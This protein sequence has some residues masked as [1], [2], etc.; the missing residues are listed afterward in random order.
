MEQ[1]DVGR[2]QDDHQGE[3]QQQPLDQLD[4]H[5]AR[6]LAEVAAEPVDHAI[7][8]DPARRLDAGRRR[9]RGV[10]AGNMSRA[11]S[12]SRT[13]EDASRIHPGRDGAPSAIAGRAGP[14]DDQP[15]DGP[16]GGLADGPMAFVARFAEL[17]HL[18][19]AP[20]HGVRAAR[21]AGPAR[22]PP[23]AAR[24]CSCRRRSSPHPDGRAGRGAAPTSRR[25]ARRRSRRA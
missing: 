9:R 16:G 25:Q 19:R 13:A 20:R 10:A 4:G 1:P 18:A 24:R 12:A 21:R 15:V 5:R 8:A 17:E 11:A 2:H 7:E 6:A 3:R 22:R 14:D 23:S